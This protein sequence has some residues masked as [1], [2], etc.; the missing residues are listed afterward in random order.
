M[1]SYADICYDYTMN[2]EEADSIDNQEVEPCRVIMQTF[3]T[4][5]LSFKAQHGSPIRLFCCKPSARN[6]DVILLTAT[7]IDGLRI[8]IPRARWV[9]RWT[10]RM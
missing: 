9:M 4:Q 2:P 1:L 8:L 5:T 7:A 3:A 6:T 10:G